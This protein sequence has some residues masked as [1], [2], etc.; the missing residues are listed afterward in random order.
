MLNSF[1]NQ[2]AGAARVLQDVGALK[3]QIADKDEEIAKW[4]VEGQLTPSL[5]C[6]L[7]LNS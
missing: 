5:F 4:K 2:L 7:K 1:Q 6:Y 3:Q